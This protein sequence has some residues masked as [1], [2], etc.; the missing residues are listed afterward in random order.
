MS[1]VPLQCPLCAGF[2]QIDRSMAGQQVQCPMCA[3]VLQLPPVE[4]LDQMAQQAAMQQAPQ[5]EPAPQN[6]APQ[7]PAGD[8]LLQLPCPA[9]QQGMTVPL[10]MA[11]QQVGCPFCSTPI[12]LPPYEVFLQYLGLATPSGAQTAAP[13][14]ATPAA[15]TNTPQQQAKQ[16]ADARHAAAKAALARAKEEREKRSRPTVMDLPPAAPAKPSSPAATSPPPTSADAGTR[17]RPTMKEE[18]R[19]LAS[20][21]P[22]SEKTS[23][24]KPAAEKQSPKRD[25]K[26]PPGFQSPALPPEEPKTTPVKSAPAKTTEPATKPANIDSL[27]PP[28][29]ESAASP[30]P[31]TT[32]ADP[33]PLP[34]VA[35]PPATSSVSDLLPPGADLLPPMAGDSTAAAPS[36]SASIDSLLPPGATNEFA[37]PGAAMLQLE[38]QALAAGRPKELADTLLPPTAGEV[39]MSTTLEQVALP[40]APRMML[41]PPEN[42]APGAVAVPTEDGGY[43][44]VRE[45][46]KTIGKG[47]DEIELRRLTPEEKAKRRMR[48]NI[49]MFCICM[50][51]LGI[52]TAVMAYW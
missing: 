37:A 10:S 2:L 14:T 16:D 3:G 50:A 11:G 40:T 32:S 24:E 8:P 18:R 13:Q 45:T 35:T 31:S 6:Y 30:S 41:P 27:L 52:I 23:S 25:D 38:S 21:K 48:R 29:A 42:L 39:V 7:A 36:G 15:P 9:C 19:P 4:I 46:P 1:V 43:V 33:A 12:A 22:S 34:Q 20:P 5:Q 26:Y 17:S 51:L 44:T 28:G 49:I 47:D